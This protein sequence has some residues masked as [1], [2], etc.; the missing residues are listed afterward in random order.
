MTFWHDPAGPAVSR[1][2]AQFGCADG[3]RLQEAR[4][5]LAQ[6]NAA[7]ADA[8]R[9]AGRTR[10]GEIIVSQALWCDQG[11]HPFSGRD[12]QAE[13]WERSTRDGDGNPV[14]LP[15]DVCG[16]CLQGMASAAAKPAAA[17]D[18][19]AAASE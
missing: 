8:E 9:L 4:A 19:P 7:L 10:K 13:H 14:T 18:A 6:A 15:W 1:M 3:C 12:R 11:N 2:Q 17:L 5:L 16:P